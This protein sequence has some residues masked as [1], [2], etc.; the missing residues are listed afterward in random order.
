M[1]SPRRFLLAAVVAAALLLGPPKAEATQVVHLDTR[2]LTRESS[3]IVI[4][5]VGAQ[6]VH[7]N[8]AH[9]M[10][11]TDVT[12]QVSQSLKGATGDLT[13]TQVG[14][15][16]DGMRYAVEGSPSFVSGEEVLVFAWRD[17]SG[18]AQVDGL[19]QGKFE[20]RR[21]AATGTR[22][23]QRRLPG[24]EVADVKTLRAAPVG[25]AAPKPTLDEFVREIQA[26]LAE[27]GR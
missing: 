2:G 4:G 8:D 27:A 26:A 11:L 1:P 21:D 19:A 13:L 25:R 5:T 17:A 20:I 14:G 7:W 12:V 9:T 18:R 16:I 24:L 23:V 10:I 3:D 15:E 22:M 6:R